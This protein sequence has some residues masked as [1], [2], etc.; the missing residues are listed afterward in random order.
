MN[1]YK[2]TLTFA[3]RDKDHFCC[4]VLKPSVEG[5]TTNDLYDKDKIN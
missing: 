5:K 1:E 2:N 4:K 3:F